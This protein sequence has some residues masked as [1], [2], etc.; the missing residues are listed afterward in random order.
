MKPNTHV[1]VTNTDTGESKT[2]SP[3]D[4]LPDWAAKIVKE[5]NSGV[6]ETPDEEDQA[7]TPGP[8]QSVGDDLIGDAG[9]SEDSLMKRSKDDLVTLAE[10]EGAQ[11]VSDSNTKA[12]LAAAIRATGYD[13]E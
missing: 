9:G 13:G 5:G 1:T 6:L 11:G 7:P 8:S 10:Q 2:F 4:D 12:E 3:D